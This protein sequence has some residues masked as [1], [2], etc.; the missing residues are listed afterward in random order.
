MGSWVGKGFIIDG[1]A[2]HDDET[3]ERSTR[4]QTE[5]RTGEMSETS[6][7][8]RLRPW[9]ASTSFCNGGSSMYV[10]G[11]PWPSG[12]RCAVG[13]LACLRAHA[14]ARVSRGTGT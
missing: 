8:P 1:C 12:V 14:R 3:L 10:D 6:A 13:L 4:L 9:P 11:G 5:C 2:P 7:L